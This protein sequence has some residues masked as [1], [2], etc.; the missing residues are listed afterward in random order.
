MN[1]KEAI[2]KIRALFEDMPEVESEVEEEMPVEMAE[3]SLVDGT[4]VMINS[5]E[6]GGEV[7]L[8]DG[9][10]APDAEHTLADGTVITT[11]SGII[12]E[13][14]APESVEEVEV[15]AGDKKMEEKMA[16]VVAEFQSKIDALASEKAALESKL[17]E[18]EKKQKEGFSAV[19]NLIEEVTR[20]PQADPTEQPQSFKFEAT[21]DIKFERLNKYRNAILNNKN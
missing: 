9:T 16:E 6:V 19:L 3:Y 1:P 13:I 5:L 20:M 4:K 12:K 2:L 14:E 7:K 17:A 18:I 11:E 10:L 8:E 21:K 15:E